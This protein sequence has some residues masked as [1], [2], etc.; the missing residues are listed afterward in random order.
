VFRN[1]TIV[2]D[3]PSSAFA[4]RINREGDNRAG[5]A[6]RFFNNV[7]SDPTGTMA[8]FS[9]TAAGDVGSF[10]LSHNLYWNGGSNIPFGNDDVLNYTADRKRVVADP[11]LADPRDLEPPRWL[12]QQGT[13][14]GGAKSIAECRL[15]LIERYGRPRGAALVGTADPAAAPHDDIRGHARNGRPDIGAY[16]VDD[17]APKRASAQRPR[18]AR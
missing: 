7:W 14:A 12:P 5:Q 8:D 11:G 1:N 2:G 4:A 9:D 3:L 17:P 10:T 13:F 18:P 6:I 16:Q 15:S